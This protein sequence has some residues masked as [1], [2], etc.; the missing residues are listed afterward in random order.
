M[1]A[2][3]RPA[4]HATLHSAAIAEA[5]SAEDRSTFDAVSGASAWCVARSAGDWRR[6]IPGR[7]LGKI[8][9]AVN[10]VQPWPASLRLPALG[11]AS[12][13]REPDEAWCH[14]R[15]LIGRRRFE[16]DLSSV[17]AEARNV[18]PGVAPFRQDDGERLPRR[19]RTMQEQ[20]AALSTGME[21][22]PESVRPYFEGAQ[23]SRPSAELFGISHSFS[24][25][26]IAER[27]RLPSKIQQHQHECP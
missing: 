19:N 8:A 18:K 21:A 27:F 1:V 26:P 7:K 12:Q 6:F 11:D 24:P 13:N 25:R 2:L 9:L 3:L 10:A 14:K 15:R 5:S 20:L 4:A 17:D 16:C 22:P 23:C